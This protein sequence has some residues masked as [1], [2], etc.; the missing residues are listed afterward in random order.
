ME[1]DL[2]E[3]ESYLEKFKDPLGLVSTFYHIDLFDMDKVINDLKTGDKPDPKMLVEDPTITTDGAN[4]DQI[5]DVWHGAISIVKKK[6]KKGNFTQAEKTALLNEM[7][8]I[9]RTIKKTM[10]FDKKNNCDFMK[11][12]TWKSFEMNKIGPIADS[13]FGWRL[14]FK[15]SSDL[16]A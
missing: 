8:I 6:S 1:L 5:R 14:S 15:I 12:L 13:H 9:C 3:F 16:D 7:F 4:L 11:H 10:I 2:I